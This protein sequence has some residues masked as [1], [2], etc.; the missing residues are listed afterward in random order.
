MECLTEQEYQLLKRLSNGP[1]LNSKLYVQERAV[2]R[3]LWKRGYVS[4]KY[5][6]NQPID[7]NAKSRTTEEGGI[8]CLQNGPLTCLARCTWLE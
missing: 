7:Q 2:M 1:V 6:E 3:G 8:V 5:P 4:G